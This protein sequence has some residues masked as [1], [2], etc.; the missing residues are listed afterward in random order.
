M[1]TDKIRK[2]LIPNIPYL[3]ILWAFL[4]LGTAYR[5]A[6]GNDFA[7][8]LIGL[9]QTIGPAFADFAP[10]LAPL[11]WLIGIAFEI[12]QQPETNG[13]YN[14]DKPIQRSKT[15]CKVSKGRANRLAQ[16][17]ELMCKIVTCRQPDV[18]KRQGQPR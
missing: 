12:D 16:P 11:D 18:Y 2:Y 6:A 1:R 7:H 17:D 13:A 15:G 5:L 9:G 14:T 10:G 3:F 4:K 8:K